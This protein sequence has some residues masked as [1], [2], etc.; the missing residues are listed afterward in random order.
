MP[1]TIQKP[2][3]LIE[4]LPSIYH[5]DALLESFLV[6]F[7]KLLIGTGDAHRK[8]LEETIAGIAT[9]FDP[10]ITPPEFLTWLAGW[11]AFTLRADVPQ[12]AQRKFIAE[13]IQRYRRRGTVENLRQLLA[14][15]VGGNHQVTE[16]TAGEFQIGVHSTVGVDTWVDGGPAH[17]FEV[18][19]SLP[20]LDLHSAT[21]TLDRLTKIATSLIDLEKP[22]HTFYTLRFSF[23][24]MQVGYSSTVGVDTLIGS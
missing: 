4:Y 23:P 19:I 12:D 6:A 16:T 14:I 20:D 1:S 2:V 22:A 21:T 3:G 24:T 13:I 7:E 17:F 5:G 11:T 10:Q 15:F 9:L 18:T 8:S